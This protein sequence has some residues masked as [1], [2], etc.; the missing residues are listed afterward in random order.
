MSRHPLGGVSNWDMVSIRPYTVTLLFVLVEWNNAVFYSNIAA[1]TCCWFCITL[2]WKYHLSQS[3][4]LHIR[5]K[6]RQRKWLMKYVPTDYYCVSLPAVRTAKPQI[7]RLIGTKIIPWKTLDRLAVLNG[8][9][10]S[11]FLLFWG[12]RPKIALWSV[13]CLPLLEWRYIDAVTGLL[14]PRDLNSN[15]ALNIYYLS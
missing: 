14:V 2:D 1:Y 4:S 11:W 3:C 7:P 13:Y 6:L 10:R 5:Q 9:D 15:I 8:R 12:V